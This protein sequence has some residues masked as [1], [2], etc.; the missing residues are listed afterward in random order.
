MTD[1]I[2]RITKEKSRIAHWVAEMTNKKAEVTA[3][4]HLGTAKN[5][6]CIKLGESM[7]S[8][9]TNN[10]LYYMYYEYAKNYSLF[11]I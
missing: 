4:R 1:K 11:Q 5:I 2:A 9:T 3:R 10:K 7:C 6:A 8:P